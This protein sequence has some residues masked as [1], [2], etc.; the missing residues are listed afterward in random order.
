MKLIFKRFKTLVQWIALGVFAFLL[1]KYITPIAF[2]IGVFLMFWKRKIG[3]GLD[4]LSDD[5]KDVAYT[6]DLLGNVTIFN[7]LWFLFKKKEG[8]PFGNVRE[9]ISYVLKVNHDKGTLRVFGR[10][11]YYI[12]NKIDNGHFDNLKY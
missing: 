9:T 6:L 2:V 11:L 10:G 7:W 5:I 4:Q 3:N 1:L 8:Y 12:I